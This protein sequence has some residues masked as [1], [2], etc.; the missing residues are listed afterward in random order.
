MKKLDKNK[1]RVQRKRRIRAKMKG[2]AKRPRLA[3]FKSLKGIYAQIIDD[4]K[5][6]TI[7]QANSTEAKAKND[8]AG[9]VKVG[10][11]I[12]KK[13]LDKKIEAIVFDRSGYKYHGKVKALADAARKA[14]LKF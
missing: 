11:L 14:G 5:G 2:Y 8:M 6:K 12:A 4:A 10:E 13:C 9:A 7:V 3:V 1:L